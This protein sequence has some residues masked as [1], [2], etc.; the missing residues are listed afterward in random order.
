MSA[1]FNLI[2]T[3][4][5]GGVLSLPYAFSNSGIVAGV[6]ILMVVGGSADFSVYALVSW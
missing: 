4:V 5:G 3:M 1:V 2:S 6:L